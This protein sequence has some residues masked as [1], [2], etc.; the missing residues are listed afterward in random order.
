LVRRMNSNSNIPISM[1]TIDMSLYPRKHI[2]QARV[3]KYA[4]AMRRGD[5][6]PAIVIAHVEGERKVLDGVHRIKA[7]QK[8]KGSSINFED[9]GEMTRIEAFAEAVRLNGIHGKPLQR[10]ERLEA[11]KRLIDEGYA[12]EKAELLIT[13]DDLKISSSIHNPQRESLVAHLEQFNKLLDA[14]IPINDLMIQHLRGL[15][16]RIE[17]RYD[18]DVVAKMRALSER[19]DKLLKSLKS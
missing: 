9:R 12:P 11:Y 1:L 16:N 15:K 14:D 13:R 18:P 8:I 17:V 19:I 2:D 4:A 7:T 5:K 6:F 3:D 10:K